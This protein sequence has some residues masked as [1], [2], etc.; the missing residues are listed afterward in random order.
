MALNQGCNLFKGLRPD[1]D[2]ANDDIRQR[3]PSRNCHRGLIQQ[4]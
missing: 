3:H 4:R 1:L 2:H